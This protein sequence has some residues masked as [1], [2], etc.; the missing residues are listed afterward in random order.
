MSK[1]EKNPNK[2]GSKIRSS[3]VIKLNIKMLGRMLVAFL[4]LNIFILVLSL[5][6][7]VWKKEEGAQDII[8]ILRRNP[9]RMESLNYEN[10]NY[11]ILATD[12]PGQ[13]WKIP[14]TIEKHLVGEFA[15][16]SRTVKMD[17][18]AKDRKLSDRLYSASYIINFKLGRDFYQLVYFLGSDLRLILRLIFILLIGEL[19]ILI[20]SIGKGSR[21][22]RKTLQPLADLAETAKSLNAEVASMGPQLADSHI[23]DLAGAISN[24]DADKLDSHI[25]I[26]SS[27][28]EL[29]DLA[30]A[31]NNMLNRINAAYQSQ[32]R[33][34]SDA[35]HELRTPIAVIQ[36]Y[37]NLLDRWGKHD[38]E[39]LEESIRAIKSET[40]SMQELVEQLLFL[41]RGDNE[42]IQLHQE[43]FAPYELVEDI[44]KE[45]Q[46][47][48]PSHDFQTELDKAAYIR[49]DKQLVK[50]AIRILV[51]NSIKF[52]PR[53][54]RISLKVLMQED[55]VE[56]RV[57]DNG[58]GIEAEE[59]P[60]IFNRFYRSDESR[61]RETG[62]TGLGL[63]IAKWI[64]ERHGAY[65]EVVSRL[66][67]GTRISLIFPEIEL[68]EASQNR[69]EGITRT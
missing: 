69:T 28:D 56:I 60:A 59:V 16:T 50:Q 11:E 4:G 52:T 65:F 6:L 24:I 47:I 62:G 33:F 17:K 9:E 51:D 43:V 49:G 68:A 38:E 19:V 14:S 39:T 57:Q 13:G 34:V 61:A 66:G 8:R 36:G 32:I 48:D 26:D 12:G 21:T 44:V 31:I 20:D 15:N 64:I 1:E 18:R 3:L 55:Q 25:S 53:G 5:G 54:E 58:I 46:M 7:L 2:L 42:T 27:Q 67:I 45:S 10:R 23:K 29:K 40:E 35:S 22:I 63:A 37:A 41:A 30:A